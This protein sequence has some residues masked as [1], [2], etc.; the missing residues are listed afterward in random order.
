MA[1]GEAALPVA[2]CGGVGGKSWAQGNCLRHIR[3]VSA[4]R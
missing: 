4:P 2:D 3:E 1:D